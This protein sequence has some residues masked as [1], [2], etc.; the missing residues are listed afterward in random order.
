MFGGQQILSQLICLKLLLKGY[1]WQLHVGNINVTRVNKKNTKP[2]ATAISL[3]VI[4][5]LNLVDIIKEY[6][7]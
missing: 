1:L 7:Q 5:L 4:L 6:F 3:S 2:F